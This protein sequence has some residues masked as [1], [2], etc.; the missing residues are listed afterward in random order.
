M[1]AHTL[2][3]QFLGLTDEM[4]ELKLKHRARRTEMARQQAA[5]LAG[6]RREEQALSARRA[7]V[8]LLMTLTGH[9]LN[10]LGLMVGVSGPFICQLARKAREENK[11]A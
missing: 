7:Q 5:E 11:N 10:D 8:A 6:M 1:N 2:A 9:N 4:D 3:A